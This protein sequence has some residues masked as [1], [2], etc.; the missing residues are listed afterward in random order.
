MAGDCDGH[1][2][3]AE[4]STPKEVANAIRGIMGPGWHVHAAAPKCKACAQIAQL[5]IMLPGRDTRATCLPRDAA[6]FAHDRGE[7]PVDGAS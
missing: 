1:A 3:P 6:S 2:D 4:T 7:P 5:P